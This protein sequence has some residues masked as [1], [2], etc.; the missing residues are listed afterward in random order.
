MFN[1]GTIGAAVTLDDSQY[2]NKLQ[3]LGGET[4]QMLGKI[5]GIAGA[6]LGFRAL[7]NAVTGCVEAFI[8]QENAVNGLNRALANKGGIEYSEQLQKLAGDLQVV[9]TYGD[10]ATMAAMKLGV[11]M[12]IPAAQMEDATKAAMGLSA[13]YEM[14]LNTA[15]QL[16]AKANAGQTGTLSRYGIV[17]DQTKSKEEQFI[18][19][20]QKGKGAFPLAEAQTT[21]QK[22]Q[23]L[24]NVW[25][26]LK[27]VVGQ[28]LVELFGV[29]GSIQDTS[30]AL[31]A[32]TRYIEKNMQEWI[33]EIK[34][35]FTYFEAGIKAVW[36]IFEP[37]VTFLWESFKASM[38]NIVSIAQWGIENAGN[39]FAS[40]PE[41]FAGIGKDI[42]QCWK[43]L[44]SGLL[45]LAGNLGKA[46]WTA[47]KGG[48]T[49]GFEEAWKKL[50]ADAEKTTGDMGKFTKEALVKAGVSAF[51]ELKS[52]GDF[53]EMLKKY[54]NIGARLEEIDRDRDKKQH[55][56]ELAYAKKLE[57][58][59]GK[60]NNSGNGGGAENA[61]SGDA[62]VVGNFSTAV[63]S[64]MLGK[65]T[66][67]ME[68]A[69][70]T[71][72]MVRLQKEQLERSENSAA[73]SF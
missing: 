48:G 7:E 37:A 43:N 6:Y 33:F 59:T 54:G 62:D 52:G 25:G 63:L 35:V 51:P 26:D 15:M 72:E 40:L 21:G 39:I 14:D 73:Y 64:A 2:R 68:T 65:G 56:L 11:N 24:K 29:N 16:V 8:V 18:E 30:K 13:A 28:F 38:E 42:L 27:E 49:G 45:H 17:L 60:N 4:K 61:G 41:I 46:I 19:L 20:L 9:T 66:P 5:A 10:E 57:K 50:Q 31:L 44:F 12:G 53:G 58:S 47:M 36:A 3:K 23:Q 71:R 1:L 32:A 22:L 69:Q 70:N 67:E 34:Y 55:E